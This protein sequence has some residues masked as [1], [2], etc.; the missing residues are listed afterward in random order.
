VDPVTEPPAS[1]P[2]TVAPDDVDAAPSAD[3]ADSAEGGTGVAGG[4]VAPAPSGQPGRSWLTATTVAVLVTAIVVA[5]AVG[6]LAFTG[7]D[8]AESPDLAARSVLDAVRRNDLV[9]IVELLPPGERRALRDPVA[10]L[11]AHLQTLRLV[12]RLDPSR[13]P[14]LAFAFDDLQLRTTSLGEDV[15][16]V[17]IVGGSMR[18]EWMG[19][20]QPLSDHARQILAREWGITID[21][22]E[23]VY[24]RDFARD[25]LRLV[26]VKEGGGWHVSLAYTVAEAIRQD[27]GAA[28]PEM[29]GGPAATGADHPDQAATDLVRAYADGHPERLVTLLYPNEA[30]SLYDYS[31]TFLPKAVEAA[32]RAEADDLYDVQ[33]NK[34]ET[35]VEGKGAERR[36]RITA[37]DIDIRDELHKQHLWWADGCFHTDQRINDDDEPYAKSDS[38]SRDRPRPG[39]ATAPRDNPVSALAV[40][41][42]GSDLPTFTVIER[43]GRWF[44]SPVHTLA[45]SLVES[46]RLM[47]PD[48]LDGFAER[49][50]DTWD[51]GAGGGLSGEPIRPT[52]REVAADPTKAAVRGKALADRCAQLTTG[53][54]SEAVTTACLKRLVTNGKVKIEDLPPDAQAAVR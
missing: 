32:R 36:V 28:L 33:L 53:V 47:Q 25:D 21:Q 42:G 18:A 2:D 46:A 39:D 19:G 27:R 5:S 3:D 48:D 31:S 40:F 37:L 23:A 16:A 13:V 8:G 9:G 14:G 43:N 41:G 1:P 26:A 45:D 50:A 34:L 15:Q 24:T 44:V 17:D 10:E 49:W 11:A 38:C 54:D 7:D 30:R 51:A 22:V 52:A 12:G 4:P 20:G 35:V 29:G 6:V